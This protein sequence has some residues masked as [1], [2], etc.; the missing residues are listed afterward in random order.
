VLRSV[1]SGRFTGFHAA[2]DDP[3]CRG[4]A[5]AGVRYSRISS[6]GILTSGKAC[7]TSSSRAPVPAVRLRTSP[8]NR[9]K[10]V[11]NA[12][13]LVWP[14]LMLAERRFRRL[15][16]HQLLTALAAGRYSCTVRPPRSGVGGPSPGPH[17]QTYWQDL[18]CVRDHG[19]SALSVLGAP[20]G[21]ATKLPYYIV[22]LYL[23]RKDFLTVVTEGSSSHSAE[24]VAVVLA[25][26]PGTRMTGR[27]PKGLVS[28]AGRRIAEWLERCLK[29][30]PTYCY[31]GYRASDWPRL[32]PKRWVY[33]TFEAWQS[34]NNAATLRYALTQVLADPQVRS[35]VVVNGDVVAQPEVVLR[36]LGTGGSAAAVSSTGLGD[37]DMMAELR[38]GRIVQLAKG[39]ASGIRAGTFYL[40]D[41]EYATALVRATPEHSSGWFERYVSELAPGL[42][43]KA[44]D[45]SDLIM[46]ELDTPDDV[47]RLTAVLQA[48]GWSP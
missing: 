28:V 7:G 40:L 45:M 8:A 5:G 14:L 47:Q 10:Q 37:E 23:A 12:T 44:V 1:H 35:V 22:C 3:G 4:A 9:F 34:T 26:G 2:P 30:L 25:A 19:I 27:L 36:L 39:L 18:H 32:G 33:R 46:Y 41:R 13:A 6:T 29:D 16:A 42:D 31:V 43:L 38:D 17:L 48:R 11:G 20:L 15:N 21:C 24:V